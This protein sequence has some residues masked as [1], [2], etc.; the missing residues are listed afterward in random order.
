MTQVGTARQWV[1]TVVA[2][3]HPTVM[4]VVVGAATAV[5]VVVVVCVEI[6]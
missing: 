5:V 1:C 3:G 2:V 6:R 4:V